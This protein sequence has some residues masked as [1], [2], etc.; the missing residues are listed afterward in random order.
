VTATL[1]WLACVAIAWAPSDPPAVG[2]HVERA[3]V[4][5]ATVAA[6]RYVI[7]IPDKGVETEARVQGFNA[8]G[9]E[10]PWSDPLVLERVHNFDA[11][12]SGVT[13]FPDLGRFVAAFNTTSADFDAD[14][15]GVVDFPDF[16]GFIGAFGYRYLASGLVE[17]R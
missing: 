6:N 17:A 5:V 1:I 11:D 4:A 9:S 14:G 13:G 16:G 10:S 15:S 2:Y 7:C 12:G 3:G 8:A